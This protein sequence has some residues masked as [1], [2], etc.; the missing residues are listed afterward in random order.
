MKEK[1]KKIKKLFS[2]AKPNRFWSEQPKT[3]ESE[4]RIVDVMETK[5]NFMSTRSIV[6]ICSKNVKIGFKKNGDLYYDFLLSH[7][8]QMNYFKKWYRKNR[9]KIL[10]KKRLFYIALKKTK[11]QKPKNIVPFDKFR[12]SIVVSFH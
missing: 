12:H 3:K 2:L 11:T 4:N 8:I 10:E 9:N 6:K 5:E 7:N 1:K